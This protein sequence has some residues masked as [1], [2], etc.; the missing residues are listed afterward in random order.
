MS[1]PPRFRVRLLT[2]RSVACL[3]NQDSL[4]ASSYFIEFFFEGLLVSGNIAIGDN[5]G[6]RDAIRAA[7]RRE[8]R[9]SVQLCT[10]SAMLRSAQADSAGDHDGG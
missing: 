4:C 1:S 5:A 6:T 2:N 3:L 8:A 9:G 10:T 7:W